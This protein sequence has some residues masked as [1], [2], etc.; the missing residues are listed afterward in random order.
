MHATVHKAAIEL[1]EFRNH[2]R[3]LVLALVGMAI[4]ANAA[5]LYGFGALIVP[6]QEEFG[7][8]RSALQAAISF[9]Y[10]AA[11][12]GLSLAGWLSL[13]FGIKK[14]AVASFFLTSLVY[15]SATQLGS[16][17]WSLYLVFTLLPILGTECLS[18]TWAQLVSLWFHRNRGL[19]LAIAL[20]GTGIAAATMPLLLAWS[21]Q[22]W[23]WRAGF[24]IM[25]LLNLGLAL[26]LTVLWLKVP[27]AAV[28]QADGRA[29]LM[30]TQAKLTGISYREGLTSFTFWK[31]NI[32]LA[33]TVSSIIAIATSTIPMLQDRGFSAQ[34]ASLIFSAFGFS[35]IVGRLLVG[36]LLD[37][38]WPPGVAGAALALPALGCLIFLS[39]S[40]E[41]AL[42]ALAAF[43]VGFGAGAEM[44]IAAFLVARYFGLREYGRLFGVHLGLVTVAAALA[45]CWL[46]RSLAT[47]APIQ[48]FLSMGWCAPSS[49]PL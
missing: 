3:V 16:S 39:G 37:R 34:Q 17:I 14:V 6:L 10:G 19:A 4:S 31:L 15:F 27:S 8:E 41:I 33:L 23:D 43:L 7:W 38:L 22:A 26:P 46:P 13:R 47:R 21:V 44:D 1:T 2:W 32:A 20:S 42:M 36:Y 48:V 18:V 45:P 35:L 24:V 30:E 5:L 28:E 29:V 25:G 12:V 49:G 11:V 9:L 40:N